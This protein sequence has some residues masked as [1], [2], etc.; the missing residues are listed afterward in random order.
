MPDWEAQPIPEGES[1]KKLKK[2]KENRQGHG[3]PARGKAGE[4]KKSK[5]KSKRESKR[6]R[7]GK[8]RTSKQQKEEKEKKQRAKKEKKHRAKRGETTPKIERHTLQIELVWTKKMLLTNG[9]WPWNHGKPVWGA[10]LAFKKCSGTSLISES[11]HH[12]VF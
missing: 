10:R 12:D 8:R 6:K 7:S 1:G 2:Q 4:R 11:D 3:K 9:Q 5:E